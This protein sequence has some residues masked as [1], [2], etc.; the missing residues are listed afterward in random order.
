[1]PKTFGNIKTIPYLCTTNLKIMY[2]PIL[3]DKIARAILN[4][5]PTFNHNGK[6]INLPSPQTSGT[7]T[8]Q[9]A[10]AEQAA[11]NIQEHLN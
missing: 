5:K 6:K 3:V 2:N 8:Q 11:R 4:N 10:Y 1:M 9:K 7:Y